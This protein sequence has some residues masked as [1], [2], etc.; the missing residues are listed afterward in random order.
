MSGIRQKVDAFFN[1]TPG[2]AGRLSAAKMLDEEGLGYEDDGEHMSRFF[3]GSKTGGAV[4]VNKRSIVAD[5][6][7]DDKAYKGKKVSR[8]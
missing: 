6:E 4:E 8:A 5:I 2:G 3:D 1:P 7:I